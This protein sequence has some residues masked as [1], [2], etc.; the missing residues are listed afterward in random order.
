MTKAASLGREWLRH[1]GKKLAYPL[2]EALTAG[3]GIPRRVNGDTIRF[4]VR[5]SR[6]YPSVYEP[7]KH[8]FLRLH[9]R[10][11]WDALDI[12]AHLGLFTVAMARCVA[13]L[14]RVYS[15]EPSDDTRR[16][17]AETV[18]F[19]GC[20]DL[21]Y[22][23]PEAVSSASGQA[24]FHRAETPVCNSNGLVAGAAGS[25]A[26]MVPIV[27]VDEFVSTHG[28]RIT[29][30]KIDA[31]GSEIEILRGAC[32][33]IERWRPALAVEIHPK[34]LNNYGAWW[35]E[36]WDVARSCRLSWL[37]DGKPLRRDQ[38]ASYRECVEVQAVPSESF[39]R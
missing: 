10:P 29:C 28:L 18:R 25:R 14:G 13:P 1:V 30:I 32:R 8:R 37:M 26:V 24:L 35:D 5:W 6:Y 20:Q 9:C 16:A 19:N 38:L 2:L 33:T 17:L 34:L 12:G 36:L 39:L 21:V 4:P 3:R 27:S 23:R 31:E 7:A 15:F 22:V 11:G